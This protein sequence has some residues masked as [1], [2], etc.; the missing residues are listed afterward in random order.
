VLGRAGVAA[1]GAGVPAVV[2]ARILPTVRLPIAI[3]GYVLGYTAVA[4]IL[5]AAYGVRRAP[6]PQRP[7]TRSA[8]HALTRPAVRGLVVVGYG[9]AAIALPLNLGLTHAVPVGPRWWLLPLLW[10][11]FAVLAYGAERTAGGNSLAVLL[12]SAVIVI[13]LVGAAVVGLT[14]GFVLLVAVPLALLFGWQAVWSAVLNR[15]GAPPWLTALTGSVVVAW[16]IAIALPLL[17]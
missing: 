11:G 6:H 13:G 10:A 1:I 3:G 12:V 17:G 15:F 4:G 7:A 14:H 5:L 9:V 16:P 2:L 8:G